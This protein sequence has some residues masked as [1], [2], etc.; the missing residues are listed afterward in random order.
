MKTRQIRNPKR[1]S[2]AYWHSAEAGARFA[3]G[4]LHGTP[5]RA[6]QGAFSWRPDGSWGPE[7]KQR[8]PR[9]RRRSWRTWESHDAG[10]RIFSIWGGTVSFWDTGPKRRTVHEGG[11]S[12]SECNPMLPG[13]PWWEKK[14]WLPRNY[15]IV[16]QKGKQ[17]WICKEPEPVPSTS[18]VSE[19]IACLRLLMLMILQ[20]DHLPP[21]FPPPVSKSFCLFMRC[22]PLYASYCAARLCFTRDCTVRLKM[23]YFCVYFFNVLFV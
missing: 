12:H 17:N 10:K 4:R 5:S 7:E 18:G 23:F 19:I 14:S 1:S 2:A 15:W 21:P 9:G 16:F 6:A 20:L 13:H 11:R 8:E 3:W 22:Q